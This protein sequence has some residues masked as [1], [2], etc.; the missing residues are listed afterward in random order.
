MRVIAFPNLHFPPGS[1]ALDLAAEVIG[2]LA[3]LP[4]VMR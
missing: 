4:G 2:S 3:D 1:D